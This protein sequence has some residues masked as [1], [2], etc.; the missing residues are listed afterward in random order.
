MIL[1]DLKALVVAGV[2]L[3][4]AF[5]IS[6]VSYRLGKASGLKFA[7]LSGAYCDVCHT[8]AERFVSFKMTIVCEKCFQAIMKNKDMKCRFCQEPVEKC[9]CV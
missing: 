4:L 9:T 5:L 3:L 1:L 6:L 8:V 2:G 7:K